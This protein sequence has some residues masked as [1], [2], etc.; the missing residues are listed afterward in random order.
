MLIQR[1]QIQNV[2]N[3]SRVNIDKLNQINVFFGANG[4]GKTSL[5]EAVHLLLMGR[6]FRHAQFKPLL[7]ENADESV[8]F[9]ELLAEDSRKMALGLSRRQEGKPTIRLDAGKL[10]TLAELVQIAPVMVLNS[11]TFEM[12]TGGSGKRREYLDWGLF[13]VEPRFYPLWRLAQRA[14]K[15]RNSLIRH[16]KIDRA[17]LELWTREY[18]RYGEQLDEL[19]TAY[20]AELLPRSQKMLMRLSP[21][22]AERID[23]SYYRG[24]AKDRELE[25]LLLESIDRDIQQGFTRT[26]PHRADLRITVGAH[27]AAEVLSR[28]Q[29]KIAV[30]GF[31]L[32]QAELLRDRVDKKSIFL[33]DDLSAELDDYHRKQFCAELQRLDLQV[34]ATCINPDELAHCWQDSKKIAMFHVEHGNVIPDFDSN[35]VRRI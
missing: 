13:H 32:A 2:R 34:L 28:G 4:S 29:L 5:L 18:A 22:V 27:S 11:D 30:A 6:T 19:R 16:G 15:Q 23:T 21:V 10:Q 25:A 9:A 24:W 17:Q 35:T 3:L 20:F 8:V 33:V 26:G 12:L 1:L 14:L 31:Y 7:T